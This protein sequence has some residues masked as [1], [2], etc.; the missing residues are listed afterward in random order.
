MDA[1]ERMKKEQIR[2]TDL[3]PEYLSQFKSFDINFTGRFSQLLF[4][5]ETGEIIMDGILYKPKIEDHG[6]HFFVTVQEGHSYKI[7]FS[8]GHI[9]LDGRV[10]DFSFTPSV[11][12]LKRKSKTG[13]HRVE[14]IA[15]LPGI[16]VS[17]HVKI[18]DQ[19]KEGDKI[20]TLEAMKMQNE[21]V[22]EKGGI[23]EKILVKV[24][25]QT[26]TNQLLAVI[27]PNKE[28]L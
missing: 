8:E 6:S 23:I 19:I 3:D 9:F 28:W 27:S 25:D 26:E 20:I 4:H 7:S 16:V 12:K 18:G 2:E 17:I 11:P 5:E 22:A 13:E 15:P 21:L 14:V 24:G 1:Q 10:V